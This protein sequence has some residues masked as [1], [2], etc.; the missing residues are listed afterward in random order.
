M[1]TLRREAQRLGVEKIYLKGG[2]MNLFLVDTRN[3]KYYNG[4]LF[5]A[6][7]SYIPTSQFSCRVREGD[8]RCIITVENVK[9]IETAVAFV[10]EIHRHA[11]SQVAIDNN[12][13]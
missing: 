3:E 5:G 13:D 8:G 4:D 2:R 12:K 6:I 7:M 11:R 10:E 1:V 9:N